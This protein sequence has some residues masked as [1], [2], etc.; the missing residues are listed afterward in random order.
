LD[1]PRIGRCTRP[2]EF[3]VIAAY[4]ITTN[5]PVIAAYDA[6]PGVISLLPH[7][8]VVADVASSIF[9]VSEFDQ[10]LNLW[11]DNPYARVR[12]N[13]DPAFAPESA[14]KDGYLSARCRME[15]RQ[16]C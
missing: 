11:V 5:F 10:Q 16:A 3:P 6:E 15:R 12:Y 14:S 7:N 4:D 2:T 13:I 9:T 8:M 1:L